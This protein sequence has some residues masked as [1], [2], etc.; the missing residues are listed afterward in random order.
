MTKA[1]LSVLFLLAAAFWL[2]RDR[3]RERASPELPMP[4]ARSPSSVSSGLDLGRPDRA[5]ASA[6][7]PAV[8]PREA[9]ASVLP[10]ARRSV[11]QDKAAL[12]DEVL[13]ARNDSDPRLE[14]AFNGLSVETRRSFRETYRRLPP[15]KRNQRGTIVYLLG[16]NLAAAEDWAFLREVAGESPCL[17]LADCSKADPDDSVGDETTLSYPALVALV[18]AERVLK[19]NRSS[20]SRREALS[21]ILAGKRSAAPVVAEEAARLEGR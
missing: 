14:S 17:S 8:P 1:A 20:E 2:L 18:Q 11:P 9:A 10:T 15:E 3:P 19:E 5:P 16:K 6:P 21:V 13:R 12:L 4:S 7:A